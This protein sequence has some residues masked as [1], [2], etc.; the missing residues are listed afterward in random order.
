[1]IP[2]FKNVIED[3]A[4]LEWHCDTRN[5]SYLQLEILKIKTNSYRDNSFNG[6]IKNNNY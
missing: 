3:V 4:S 5:N 2:V 1:M 6:G